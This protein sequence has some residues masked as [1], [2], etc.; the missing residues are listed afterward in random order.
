MPWKKKCRYNSEKSQTNENFLKYRHFISGQ[1]VELPDNLIVILIFELLMPP[2]E[3]KSIPKGEFVVMKTGTHPMRTRLR[4]FLDWGISF[5][6][7]YQTP[8]HGRRRVYYASCQELVEAIQ[9]RFHA[10][11]EEDGLPLSTR[12]LAFRSRERGI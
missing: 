5:R 3:L 6:E 8:E 12:R 1:Y 9:E 10:E 7:P 2:D 11:D 4:L